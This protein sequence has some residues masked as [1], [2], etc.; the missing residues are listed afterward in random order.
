MRERRRGRLA[1]VRGALDEADLQQVRLDDVFERLE[2]FG[3]RRGDRVDADRA[4]AVTFGDRAQE[5]AIEPVEPAFVDAF[6]LQRLVGDRAVTTPSART[7]AKSRTRRSSRLAMRGVPRLRCAIVAAP[8][9][10][11]AHVEHA[12]AALDD[13]LQFGRS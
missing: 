5:R 6:A 13:V 8:A 11:D 4:A 3:Q 2:V 12:R 7:S 10:F 9:G 1:A